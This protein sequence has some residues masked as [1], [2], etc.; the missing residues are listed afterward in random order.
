VIITAVL[1]TTWKG[2]V[3]K[4]KLFEPFS[5]LIQIDIADDMLVDGKTF[6]D[7][8]KFSELKTKSNIEIHLMVENPL[9]YVNRKIPN[10]TS[11][12]SQ[13]E[14][15]VDNHEFINKAKKLGYKVGLS[16][17]PDT[18]Y[19]QLEEY[20]TELDYVQF[21]DIQPGKQNQSLIP[22]VLLKISKFREKHPRVK[23]QVDGGVKMGNIKQL[24]DAGANN[25]VVGS[26]I[27][28]SINPKQMY[29]QLTKMTK[30]DSIASLAEKK[31][32]MIAFL[33]GAAWNE[34]E[35]P[36]K[37]AFEVAKVLAEAGY[38]IVNGGGPGVMRASTKGGHAGGGRVIAV[39]YHPNKTKRHY[40]GVDLENDFDDEIITLDYFDRTKVMLQTTQLHI[41]F[42]GSLGTL[43]ELGMSWISSWIHEPN[44]KPIIL[45]GEFWKDY[46]AV[47]DKHAKISDAEKSIVKVCTT[48]QE[49]LEYVRSLE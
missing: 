44:N 6:S 18:N 19:A 29:V 35:L 46:L 39:T 7:I 21:M 27:T 8:D 3:Q 16:V 32:K 31:I 33:G 14:A 15:Q 20:L 37:E 25:F 28:K 22:Q 42:K 36:Y 1:E 30:K 9:D 41:I 11:V 49:V 10:V 34:T 23:I 2:I 43:S 40:E 5:E 24:M 48:T 26:E 17:G 12:C 13:I 4:I 45:F 47:L 38:E